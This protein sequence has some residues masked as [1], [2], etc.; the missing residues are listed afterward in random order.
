MFHLLHNFLGYA[1]CL[2]D[3]N[4]FLEFAANN[5][6]TKSFQT[7]GYGR[8]YCALQRQNQRLYQRSLAL[9]KQVMTRLGFPQFQPEP[10]YG[11][12]IDVS[13]PSSRVPEH[14]D[15]APD[16]FVLMRCNFFLQKPDLGG[17]PIID[18]VIVDVK[19]REGWCLAA[20]RSFHSSVPVSGKKNRI[21]LSLGALISEQEFEKGKREKDKRK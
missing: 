1:L 12:F 19:E 11:N 10:E 17:D 3:Q 15:S 13:L 8:F 20:S 2:E 14:K 4:M 6:E 7:I 18:G 16:G 5:F 9:Q 21:I